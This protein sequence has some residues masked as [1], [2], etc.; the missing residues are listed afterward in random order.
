MIRYAISALLL[1]IFG[2][3]AYAAGTCGAVNGISR[4]NIHTQVFS[5][6]SNH[7]CSLYA[8][9]S[10]V[11]GGESFFALIANCS[12]CPRQG[13]T[14]DSTKTQDC[15]ATQAASNFFAW[16]ITPKASV[17]ADN[18]MTPTTETS[19]DIKHPSGTVMF[20]QDTGTT[21]GQCHVTTGG[22]SA[23]LTEVHDRTSGLGMK[24]SSVRIY[25]KQHNNGGPIDF[26]ALIGVDPVQTFAIPTGRTQDCTATGSLWYDSYWGTNGSTAAEAIVQ[27]VEYPGILQLN[28][29]K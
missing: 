14:V 19:T 1:V 20:Q 27:S 8:G 22:T 25:R 5:P 15:T 6:R 23:I 12:V 28:Q 13:C 29:G 2:S 3:Q 18:T 9:R 17:T 11:S 24:I 4:S 21:S 10:F 26:Y 16:S 7:M